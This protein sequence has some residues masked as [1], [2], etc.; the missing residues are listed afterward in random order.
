MTP[1]DVK[2]EKME[3]R[4]EQKW[5][6]GCQKGAHWSQKEAKGSQKGAKGNQKGAKRSQ[7]GAKGSQKGAKREPKG[8]QNA[9]KNRCPEKVAKRVLPGGASTWICSFWEALSITN[10]ITNLCKNRCRRRDEKNEKSVR[11]FTYLLMCF[12]KMVS[13]VSHFSFFRKRCMYGDHMNPQVEYLPAGGRTKRRKS[14]KWYK[15]N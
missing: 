10:V 6:K 15:S 11:S 13:Y 3:P 4:G 2:S 8:D 7:K 5:P 9:S 1:G 12:R 14:N